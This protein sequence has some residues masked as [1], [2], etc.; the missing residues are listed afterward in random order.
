MNVSIVIPAFNEEKLIGSTLA[1]VRESLASAGCAGEIIVVDNISTDK[2][3]QIAAYAGARVVEEKSR[4]IAAVRNRGAAAAWGETIFFLDAD[5]RISP[6][7]C[8]R[9]VSVMESPECFGGSFWV[10][11]QGFERY[12]MRYYSMGWKFWGSLLNMR[13]GAAQFCRKTAFIEISGFDE[14]IFMGED[15]DF[16]WRLAAYAKGHGGYLDNIDD[17]EVVTSS[18]RFDKMSVFRTL[19]LTHPFFIV[20]F[21]RKIDAWKEWYERPVR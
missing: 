5:T 12:W 9:I 3:A 18:R 10:T 17:I 14:T 19:I 8:Q 13:Q 15:V 21:R 6:A 16:Y 20:L 1:A 7:V 11:Y 4:N 2:T